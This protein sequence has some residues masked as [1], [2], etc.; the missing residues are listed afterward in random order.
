MLYCGAWWYT[1]N[2]VC[3][4]LVRKKGLKQGVKQF[5]IVTIA[6]ENCLTPCSSPF[7]QHG[8]FE[9]LKPTFY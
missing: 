6:I 5:F 2:V 3:S 1:G 7:P 4:C 8:Q 9:A